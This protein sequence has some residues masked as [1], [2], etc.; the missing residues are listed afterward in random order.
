MGHS[1]PHHPRSTPGPA[2]FGR[3]RG[4]HTHTLKGVDVEIPRD[5]LVVVDWGAQLDGYC[6]DCTRTLATGEVGD[7]ARAVYETVRQ[8]QLTGLDAVRAG[9]TGREVDAAARE[10]V[11][12]AGHGE[13]FGHGLGHGV[14][15]EVHEEPRLAKSGEAALEA[16]NVVTVEP[17][18]YL[19]GKLGVRI[20]DLVVV[21][22]AGHEVLTGFTKEIVHAA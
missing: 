8:A 15:L 6:S 20:E 7:E 11:E 12:A 4:A 10:V 9:P 21:T 13:R 16:G 17:G 1:H 19:P 5:A 2:G 3:V 18:V 22:G 14:G